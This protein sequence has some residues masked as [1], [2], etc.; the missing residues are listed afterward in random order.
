M[1]QMDFFCVEYG[2]IQNLFQ[3]IFFVT[4]PQG[5]GEGYHGPKCSRTLQSQNYFIYKQTTLHVGGNY[6]RDVPFDIFKM[7]DLICARMREKNKMAEKKFSKLKI[8]LIQLERSC[9]AENEYVI[10]FFLRQTVKKWE[11]GKD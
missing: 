1:H 7:A 6:P 5:A 4:P 8:F 3:H 9:R 11:P 2:S 10:I